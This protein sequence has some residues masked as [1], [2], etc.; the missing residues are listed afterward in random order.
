MEK[1][2]IDKLFGV[3]LNPNPHPK[4]G[5]Q[6]STLFIV[7]GGVALAAFLYYQFTKNRKESDD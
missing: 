6:L 5:I 7:I 4:T 1:E 3:P 2:V